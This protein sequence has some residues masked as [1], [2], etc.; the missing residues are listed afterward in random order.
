MHHYMHDHCDRNVY[1]CGVCRVNLV[2]LAIVKR[3]LKFVH[4]EKDFV[5]TSTT[6]NGISYYVVNIAKKEKKEMPKRKLIAP[7]LATETLTKRRFWPQEINQLPINPILDQL[8]YCAMCEFST[9]VRLNMVRHLQLHAE[10]Q[11]VA[12]TAPVNPVPHLETNE[13]HFDRMVNLASSS[14]VSRPSERPAERTIPAVHVT[15]EVAAKYPR[16]ISA[17]QRNTCGRAGLH[18]HVCGRVHAQAALGGATRGLCQLPLH[19]L[20]P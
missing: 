10:Q 13:K 16:H 18:L 14:L 6:E 12:Q 8:V 11:P 20:P 19:A 2:T 7:S 1:Q 17:R 4:K 3:H 15:S 5:V 9:K